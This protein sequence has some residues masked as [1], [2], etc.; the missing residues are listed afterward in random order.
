FAATV[1]PSDADLAAALEQHAERYRIPEK[2]RVHFVRYDRTEFLAQ[3]NVTDQEIA[4][5]YNEHKEQRFTDPEQVRARHILVKVDGG[6]SDAV[7]A[8]ARKKAEDLLKRVRAGE[9]FATLAKK[10]S[11][12]SGSADKGGDLGVFPHGKMVPA[13]DTAVFALE[14]GA[15]SE[16]VETPFGFHIIKLEEHLAG[17]PRPLHA[18]RDEIGNTLKRNQALELAPP[19]AEDEPRP[20]PH[21]TA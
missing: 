20:L 4:D 2:V 14:P 11:D 8:A 19:P 12:D 21:E 9:D 15:V 1:T 7:K 16:V 17:G 13:F 5:Y 10:N 6:A 3:A 18:A